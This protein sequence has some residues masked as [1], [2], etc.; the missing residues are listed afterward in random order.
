MRV[1]AEAEDGQPLVKIRELLETLAGVRQKGYAFT[2]DMV[3]R[4]GGMIAAP[5]PRMGGQPLMIVGIG[6]I[7]EVMRSR[8]AELASFLLGQI[9][10]HFGRARPPAPPFRDPAA[11]AL[12]KDRSI[13]ADM[14]LGV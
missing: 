14:L 4:G 7:S 12:A 11:R 8:E 13:F 10:S 9:E 6:G 1:N 3:T 2:C 5:L